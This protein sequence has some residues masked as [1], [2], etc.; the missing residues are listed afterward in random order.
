MTHINVPKLLEHLQ[1]LKK[2]KKIYLL[3]R[4]YKI[5]WSAR[6]YSIYI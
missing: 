3:F 5:A 1:L 2:G 6:N 4:I